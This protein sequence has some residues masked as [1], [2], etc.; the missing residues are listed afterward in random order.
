M[1][2]NYIHASLEHNA[3]IKFILPKLLDDSSLNNK[4]ALNQFYYFRTK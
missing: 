3:L 2:D 1:L 4:T